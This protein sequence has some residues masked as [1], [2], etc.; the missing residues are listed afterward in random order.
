MERIHARCRGLGVS[1]LYHSDMYK[2]VYG[3]EYEV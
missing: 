1:L 3:V 2:V